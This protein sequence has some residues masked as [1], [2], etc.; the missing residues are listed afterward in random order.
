MEPQDKWELAGI[1][2]KEKNKKIGLVQYNNVLCQK[3]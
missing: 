2:Y 1:K 3:I